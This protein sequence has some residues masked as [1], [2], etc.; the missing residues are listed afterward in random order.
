MSDLSGV[1]VVSVAVYVP[2]PVAARRLTALGAS[3]TAVEPPG[4]DAFAVWCP[5]WYAELRAGQTV[6]RMDLKDA[7]ERA[8]LAVLLDDADVLLTSARRA[9][10]G[11]LG[12]D[13]PTLHTRHPRL[14]H[15]ALVGWE[16]PADDH[17]AHD[18]NFQATLG[19]ITPP[20]LPITLFA[21][22]AGAERVVTAALSLLLARERGRGAGMAD[23]SLEGAAAP[24]ADPIRHGLTSP[25]AL[26]GGA[27]PGY[28]VYRAREGWVAVAALEPHF[29]SALV[30]G[31]ALDPSADHAALQEAFALDTA[32]HWEAWARERGLPLVAIARDIVPH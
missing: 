24:F 2:V 14:C 31:L 17:P 25:G 21:D 3:V 29:W 30:A 6:R 28:G 26:L 13:W 7:T 1:R 18:L 27:L 11:R 10:L 32:A 23:V 5:R 20:A 9:A 16:S 22:L 12:L 8:Q 15:V 19:L 4:G